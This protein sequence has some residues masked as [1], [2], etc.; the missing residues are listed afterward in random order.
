MIAYKALQCVSSSPD[1]AR[2][3]TNPMILDILARLFEKMGTLLKC[4]KRLLQDDRIRLVACSR[5]STHEHSAFIYQEV[6]LE[7]GHKLLS[8][9]LNMRSYMRR[10]YF[11]HCGIFR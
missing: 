4:V 11:A 10:A 8:N 9:P 1:L 6:S 5:D 3:D 2:Y 7:N